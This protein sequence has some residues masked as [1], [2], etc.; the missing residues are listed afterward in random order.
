MMI[1]V[2]DDCGWQSRC[3]GCHAVCPVC[4]GEIKDY[5]YVKWVTYLKK[6]KNENHNI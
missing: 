6:A 4:G 5:D 3:K 2:C 1:H